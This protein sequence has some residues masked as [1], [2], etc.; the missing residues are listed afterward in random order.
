MLSPRR[1]RAGILS[2]TWSARRSKLHQL[3][4]REI[5]IVQIQMPFPV[6][7]NLRFLVNWQPGVAFKQALVSSPLHPPLPG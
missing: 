1:V 2:A 7:A 4:P 5:M 3:E 6:P